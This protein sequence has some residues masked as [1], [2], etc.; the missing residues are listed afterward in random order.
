[1]YNKPSSSQ[2][3]YPIQDTS[4]DVLYQAPPVPNQDQIYSNNTPN[5]INT[6]M[7]PQNYIPIPTTAPQIIN[8]PV[9]SYQ[10]VQKQFGVASSI[11][12]AELLEDLA[13][14]KKASISKYFQGGFLRIGE[15]H[16]Y[17]VSIIN[18]DGSSRYIF[19]CLRDYLCLT[20]NDSYEY[21]VRM[22]YIPRD[23]TNAI[24][25]TKDFNNRLI[26]FTSNSECNYKPAIFVQ[27][28]HDH[29]TLGRIQQPRICPCCC[30][31]ALF[32]IYPKYT[33]QNIPKY[34]IT[35]NGRQCSYCCC[36]F[37]CCAGDRTNFQIY[38]TSTNLISGNVLKKN[39]KLG[40]MGD[41]F[42]I[43]DIDFP[44]DALPEEKILIICAVIGIDNA[45]YMK[46]GNHIK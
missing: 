24:L 14:V 9:Q 31:D 22:K 29:T 12:Y 21:N 13:E 32:E 5:T 27:N 30:K 42:L 41:D 17:R 3:L 2:P 4:D 10:Y 25:D 35:T 19:I 11:E 8:P 18:K 28:T 1:M 46:L 7:P 34:F 39:F 43:Y 16:K 36:V 33:Q 44:D 20:T 45:A 26:D 38:N 37:C 23:S 6:S 40:A 15:Q